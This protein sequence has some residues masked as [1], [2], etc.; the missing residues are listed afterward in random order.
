MK[1][2]FIFGML[3]LGI[4][5]VSA[6]ETF[7]QDDIVYDSFD[8]YKET[9]CQNSKEFGDIIF[10]EN[11]EY[12][13]QNIYYYCEY[14]DPKQA[15]NN[16]KEKYSLEFNAI[17]NENNFEELNENN[18]ESYYN[19]VKKSNRADVHNILVFFDTYENTEKNDE[20]TSLINTSSYRSN[21]GVSEKL[22][23]ILPDYNNI[24]TATP[25]DNQVFNVKAGVNYAENW[26]WDYNPGFRNFGDNDCTNFVSQVLQNGGYNHVN[27][28]NK[29]FGWWY[30]NNSNSNS[31]SSADKFI[32]YWGVRMST[33]SFEDFSKL[34][35]V[36]DFIFQDLGN[37]GDYN[38]AG[39]VT[40]KSNTFG[41]HDAGNMS[42]RY[43][44][45]IVAQ[46]SKNYNKWV[47]ESDNNWELCSGC[48]YATAA[49]NKQ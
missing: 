24:S 32:K 9:L 20:I 5:N 48:R 18:W 6:S 25:Y 13:N 38:H 44:D 31:W 28:I 8:S 26:A 22:S 33:T 39:F 12:N 27:G 29:Y 37:D 45:F 30:N 10:R 16:L 36:G 3:F 19:V 7:I 42:M 49:I 23:Q 21:N 17:K 15:L 40:Y 43:Y 41:V 4:T 47:S 1:K 46:H 2:L 35:S 11:G 34:I 14:S